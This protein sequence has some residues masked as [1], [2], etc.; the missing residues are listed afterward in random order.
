MARS[1]KSRL[2]ISWRQWLTFCKKRTAI[3][4]TLTCSLE[5]WEDAPSLAVSHNL[6]LGSI[7]QAVEPFHSP[8][9]LRSST[10]DEDRQE[11]APNERRTSARLEAK[12]HDRR[13]R[14]R[15]DHRHALEKRIVVLPPEVRQSPAPIAAPQPAVAPPPPVV[16]P[17]PVANEPEPVLPQP[18]ASPEPA[19]SPPRPI[20]VQPVSSPPPPPPP[21]PAQTPSPTPAVDPVVTTREETPSSSSP[22]FLATSSSAA[23]TCSPPLSASGSRLSSVPSSVGSA[24][25]SSSRPLGSLSSRNASPESAMASEGG[26]G[27]KAGA[28]AGASSPFLSSESS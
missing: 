7:I 25:A 22:L 13:K 15:L 2:P 3:E 24:S 6:S 12:M 9:F 11:Q 16:A 8:T 21:P 17:Q 26:T 1:R 23:I 28:V 20:E 10:F 18:I 27:N 4:V 5:L 19:P 14:R